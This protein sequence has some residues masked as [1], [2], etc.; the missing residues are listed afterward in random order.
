MK[1]LS[2]YQPYASLI[3]IGAKTIETRHWA[4]KYRGPLAIHAT[5]SK[6]D[7]KVWKTLMARAGQPRA[8]W[9]YADDYVGLVEDKKLRP[10]VYGDSPLYP[11]GHVVATCTLV[12]CLPIVTNQWE[13][14][15]HER[16]VLC[17]V[18]GMGREVLRL[19]ERAPLPGGGIHEHDG[20]GSLTGDYTDEIPYGDYREGRWAWLLADVKALDPP[21]PAKGRQ[22]L[23]EWH[24][25]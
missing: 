9:C 24:D 25:G 7:G 2:L 13:Q 10:W 21:V 19:A 4:T 12:D 17:A 1:A 23:W 20:Q 22:Q 8:G 15:D 6:P 11:L 18:W 5:A 3:A 14:H 16:W